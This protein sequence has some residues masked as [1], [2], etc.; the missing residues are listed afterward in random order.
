MISAEQQ[1]H[2]DD[3]EQEGEETPT[4]VDAGSEEHDRSVPGTQPSETC[5]YAVLL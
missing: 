4:D 2:D 5:N 3:D 1:D